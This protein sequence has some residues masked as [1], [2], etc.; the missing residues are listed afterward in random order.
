MKGYGM[1]VG[2]S[3]SIALMFRQINAKASARATGA[4]LVGLNALTSTVACMAG[5]FVNNWFMRQVEMENG[6]ELCDPDTN[7]PIGK[8]KLCAKSAVMQTASSRIFLAMPIAIPA[9]CLL[10]IEKVGLMP[11]SPI[12][13]IPL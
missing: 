9:F 1:A 13:S 7:E 5:G 11:K 6:I 4:R 2:A 10:A 12:L 8:S 3:V